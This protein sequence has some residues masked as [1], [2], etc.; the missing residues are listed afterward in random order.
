LA[1]SSIAHVFSDSV[2][3]NDLPIMMS[4]PRRRET[5]WPFKF[6][7]YSRLRGNDKVG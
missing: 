4:F 5:I 1:R 3:M 2:E 6:N 7:M